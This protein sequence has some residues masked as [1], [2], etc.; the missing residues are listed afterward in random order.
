MNSVHDVA[1]PQREAGYPKDMAIL[2]CA[3]PLVSRLS[4]PSLSVQASSII[5]TIWSHGFPVILRMTMPAL[6][7][8]ACLTYSVR[9]QLSNIWEFDAATLNLH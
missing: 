2:M 7:A 9:H 1:Q 6:A 5:W 4:V 8:S 3:C